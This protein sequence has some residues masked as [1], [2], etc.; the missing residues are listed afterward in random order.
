[1]L[2]ENCLIKQLFLRQIIAGENPISYPAVRREIP[3]VWV[4]PF[5]FQPASQGKYRFFK[6]MPRLPLN[7]LQYILIRYTDCQTSSNIMQDS[8]V[9]SLYQSHI[10]G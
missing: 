10:N 8:K 4:S 9:Y 6:K 7:L 3:E 1:M 2:I 5:T